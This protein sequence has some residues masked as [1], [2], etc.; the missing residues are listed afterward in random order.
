MKE[1]LT[2]AAENAQIGAIGFV[3]A[4]IFSEL[5]ERLEGENTPMTPPADERINPFLLMET[6]KT[7]IV[8]L[9]PFKKGVRTNIS[10]Y[11]KGDDYHITVRAGL[12]T[13]C[14][15]LR[16]A[17]FAATALCDSSPLCERHLAYLAGLGFVGRN[18]ALISPEFGSYVFIGTILTDAEIEPD[19]PLATGCGG[20]NACVRACPGGAL[21]AGFDAA[22]CAS[23]LTQ[24]KGELTAEERSIIKRSGYAWGCDICQ[25]V[26]PHNARVAY[27][28]GADFCLCADMAE[29]N[30][31]FRRK[32]A[33]R[34]FSWRGFEVI[35]RNLEILKSE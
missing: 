35:K 8:C 5:T 9:F 31:D 16:G 18:R 27:D 19:K 33:G 12:E 22:R 6:A 11:A 30:R 25:R 4:R 29:S 28:A 10:D 26:C 14:E 1:L 20:C 23:Y 15:I 13:L 17:G 21:S 34:A 7:V 2:R 32:Y 3:R 24:K